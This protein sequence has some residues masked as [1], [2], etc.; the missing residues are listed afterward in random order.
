MIR[1]VTLPICAA[2]ALYVTP[3][4]PQPQ[5]QPQPRAIGIDWSQIEQRQLP[6]PGSA[7]EAKVC[8]TVLGHLAASRATP[9]SRKHDLSARAQNWGAAF[10]QKTG[11]AAD[12]FAK[13]PDYALNLFALGQLDPRAVTSV[14]EACLKRLPQA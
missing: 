14:G 6:R 3:A 4:Q 1:S 8:A 7:D 13:V 2:L 11:M 5:P 9:P 10:E 12:S